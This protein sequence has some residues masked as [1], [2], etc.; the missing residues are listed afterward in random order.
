MPLKEKFST[1][2]L[3]SKKKVLFEK[4]SFNCLQ[5]PLYKLEVFF[6]SVEQ[7]NL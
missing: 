6:F 2:H 3:S 1:N 5:L 4:A 7:A